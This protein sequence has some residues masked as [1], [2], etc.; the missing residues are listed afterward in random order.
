MTFQNQKYLEYTRCMYD[1]PPHQ[2][3]DVTTGEM[4][5]GEAILH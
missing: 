5:K 3:F 1:A 2:E 4:G